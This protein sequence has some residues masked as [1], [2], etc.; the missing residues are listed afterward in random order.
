MGAMLRL[1]LRLRQVLV[2]QVKDQRKRRWGRRSRR[3]RKRRRTKKR[4]RR[5]RMQKRRRVPW[6]P[7]SMATIST[8]LL[9]AVRTLTQ[10]QILFLGHASSP[11]TRGVWWRPVTPTGHEQ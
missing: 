5:S 10:W 11:H 6:P 7:M 8:A 1:R 9:L 3:R 2:A 4:R